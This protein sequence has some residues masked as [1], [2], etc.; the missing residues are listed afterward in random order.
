MDRKCS[1]CGDVL[2]QKTPVV[3]LAA[4]VRFYA[5]LYSALQASIFDR[6]DEVLLISKQHACFL[7]VA[8]RSTQDFLLRQHFCHD[9]G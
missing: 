3:S 2:C 6:D 9:L 1:L 8:S 7:T 5:I 4:L